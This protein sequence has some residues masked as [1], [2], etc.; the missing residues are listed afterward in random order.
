MLFVL[1]I[2]LFLVSVTTVSMI[3]F[4][5]NRSTA[6]TL[7]I[8]YEQHTVTARS[9]TLDHDYNPINVNLLVMADSHESTLSGVLIGGFPLWIDTIGWGDGTPVTIN[10]IL[11]SLYSEA[12]NWRAHR[13]WSD[14]EYENL[15]YRKDIG[16]LVRCYTDRL[17]IGS[18]GSFSGSSVDISIQHSNING[19]VAR[20]TDSNIIGNTTLL[21]GIFIEVLIVQGLYIRRQK[22]K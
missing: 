5:L 16:I 21:T 7:N 11:Y 15:Y 14:F 9:Y 2:I 1:Y 12:G 20:V 22:S 4:S 3:Q 17:T 6:Y 10:G 8:E 19:L 13:S 18:T